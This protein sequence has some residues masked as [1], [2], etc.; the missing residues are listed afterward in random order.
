MK[1]LLR[2]YLIF[3]LLCLNSFQAIAQDDGLSTWFSMRVNHRI[4]KKVSM[5]AIAE[6]RMD[7]SFKTFD[8]WGLALNADYRFLPFMR[9]EGGYEI[10]HRD[11][12]PS[13]W[14]FR[15]RYGIGL[16][17]NAKWGLFNF[18]LRERF[19]Q[20]FQESD[21]ESNLRSRAEIAFVPRNSIL[22]PYVSVELY[23]QIGH[24]SFWAV[25]RIRY[26]PGL[27]IKVS[28]KWA[29]DLFYCFQYAPGGNK[30]IAGVECSF[31]F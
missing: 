27:D 30:H 15:Q 16:I 6:M 17:A 14:K 24:Q 28:R 22:S 3:L 4:A 5:S 9:L 7:D 25:D 31:S 29:L 2:F 13:G 11:R 12:G 18:S 20:T 10:H 19:Q 26:R 21:I 8:R 23:Q 1:I